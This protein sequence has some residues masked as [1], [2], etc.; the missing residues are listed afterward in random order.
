MEFFNQNVLLV[1]L[2]IGSGAMLLWPMLSR[3]S[4][5]GAANLTPNEAVLLMNRANVLILD[6]RDT[7]EFASG[8]IN[9]AKNIPVAELESRLKEIQKYKDKPVIVNCQ[10]GMRSSKA[11]AALRKLEFTQLHNLQGGVNAWTLAK[12]PLV[13]ASV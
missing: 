1:S 4:G 9:G 8:Y 10:S 11:C 6:V 12:L 3:S 5:G 7:A 13:K 2:A